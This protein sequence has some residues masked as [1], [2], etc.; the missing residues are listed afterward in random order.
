MEVVYG[1]WQ[2]LKAAMGAP[3]GERQPWKEVM[4]GQ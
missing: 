4:G 1:E 3:Y 2:P